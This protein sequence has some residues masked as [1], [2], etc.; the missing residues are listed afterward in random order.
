MSTLTTFDSTKEALQDVLRSIGQGKTQLPDFQREWVWDDEHVRG[1]LAS[2]SLAHPIGAVMMLQ[3]GGEGAKFK[4]RL[5][6]GVQPDHGQVPHL[7]RLIMD[8]QQRLTSLYQALLSGRAVLTRDLRKLPIKRW[9]YIHI[10]KSLNGADRDE[11]VLAIPEDRRVRNFRGEVTAD[12]STTEKECAAGMLPLS[13]VFDV[14]GLNAWQRT[15]MQVDGAQLRERVDKWNALTE[16]VLQPFQQYQVPLIMLRKETPKVA[17]CQVFERVNTGGVPL[18]VFELITATFAAEDFNLRK[19]WDERRKTMA[20]FEVLGKIE[21]SDFLQAVSL[22]STY[23]DRRSALA[24]GKKPDDAPGISCKREQILKLSLED[25]R[26]WADQATEG[27]TRAAKFLHG[28]KFFA[29]RDLPY[30]TQVTPLAAILATLGVRAES[31]GVK[32]K[33]ARWYWSGVFGELYGSA[34]E[35][36][37]AKDLPEVVAWIDGAVEPST[38]AEA[39]FIAKRLLTLRTRNSAAY[40]GLHALLLRDGGLD[41]RTGDTVEAQQ[42]FEEKIDVHHIFPEDWCAKSGKDRKLYDSIVNKTPLS[43]RTNRMIGGKAP[44]LYL[45]RLEKDAG[46][47][48]ARMDMILTSHVIDPLLLR[49][50][51]FESFFEARKS[52]LLSRIERVLGKPVATGIE[53]PE[54]PAYAEAHDNEAEDDAGEPQEPKQAKAPSATELLYLEFW[55]ALKAHYA[56]RGGPLK[57][58]KP[59]PQHWFTIAVGRS[60]FFIGLTASTMYN[61][62]GCEIY[63]RGPYAKQAF[64]LLAQDKAAIEEVAGPLDWQELPEGNDCRIALYRPGVTVTDRHVWDDSFAWLSEKAEVFHRAFAARVK[65]LSL[66]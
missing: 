49:A 55:N 17:V 59:R 57:L 39:N 11:A 34:I 10:D 42:Y 47:E 22:L 23:A 46:I 25:Y 58:R 21:S 18:T 2:I 12:F 63:M 13:L 8:G 44:S 51:N 54:E 37:F 19:D 28:Q 6:E 3:A 52:A 1:L 14:G 15:Y 36:R 61:R 24:S 66:G 35:T 26:R 50:D 40:K 64:K 4:P 60:K 45:P 53:V 62:L 16:K 43:A 32:Q 20:K 38:I 30:R 9:Y 41:F 65:A 27:F 33:V 48:Q 29:A 7:E 56:K 31:D 5:V